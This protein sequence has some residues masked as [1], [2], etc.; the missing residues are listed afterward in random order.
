MYAT[1]S[2]REVIKDL[3]EQRGLTLTQVGKVW[4][5]RGFGVHIDTLDLQNV[6]PDQ[7]QPYQQRKGRQW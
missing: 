6:L 2:R 7:L 5:I 4:R 3:I 1:K